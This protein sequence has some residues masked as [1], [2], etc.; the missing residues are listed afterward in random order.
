MSLSGVAS[1]WDVA[2]GQRVAALAGPLAAFAVRFSPDG[3]LLAVGDS[4]GS[5]VF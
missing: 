5:V 1:V 4:F 2:T 3:K